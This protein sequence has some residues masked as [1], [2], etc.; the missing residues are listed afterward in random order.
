MQDNNDALKLLKEQEEREKAICMEIC[1][2]IR[3][4]CSTDTDD[5]KDFVCYEIQRCFTKPTRKVVQCTNC[6]NFDRYN[7]ECMK[8]HNPNPPYNKWFCADWERK[9]DSQEKQAP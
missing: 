9:D 2:F 8:K 5:D 1:D 3:G 7:A 6:M 4:G